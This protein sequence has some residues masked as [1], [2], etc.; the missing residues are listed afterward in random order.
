MGPIKEPKDVDFIIKSEPWTEKD[1]ADFRKLI[2]K[3]REK[4]S[5]RKIRLTLKRKT[6]K[7]ERTT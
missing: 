2:R 3:Q 5:Q 1:L 7:H 6:Q 4:R